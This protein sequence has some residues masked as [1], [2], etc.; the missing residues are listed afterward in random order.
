MWRRGKAAAR[1]RTPVALEL[2]DLCGTVFPEDEAVSGYVPDSSCAYV[3]RQWFDGL[4]R[5]TACCAD[6]FETVRERYRHRPFVPEELWAAKIDC[7][8][9]TGGPVRS[10]EELGCRTGLHEPELRRG[11]AWHNERLRQV[12]E[13]GAGDV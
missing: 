13:D 8:F 3:R 9:T 2:C 12:R 7:A 11:I 10:L 1:R 4:R 5:L 6:H